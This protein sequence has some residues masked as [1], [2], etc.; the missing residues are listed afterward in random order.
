MA[1]FPAM[2]LLIDSYLGDTTHLTTL[3]HG[4]YF[5]LLLSAWRR[6]DACLPDDDDLLAR[7]TK[8]TKGQWKRIRPIIEPF[9]DVSYGRW[10]AGRNHVKPQGRVP[11]YAWKKTREIV[12]E[13]DDFSCQYCG[14]MEG[15]LECDHI[16][17]ISR[18]GTNDHKNLTTSCRRC[19]REKHDMTLSE[20]E[21][22]KN[23]Q[24]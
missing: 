3:E 8:L 15:P 5:L 21:E 1:E 24:R 12:F 19:N 18:G 17:P 4:A 2:P 6:D 14:D 10:K 22:K 11:W 23:A 9:F 7:Y 13:R 20:W 16:V